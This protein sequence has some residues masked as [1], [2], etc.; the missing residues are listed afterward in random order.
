MVGFFLCAL[1]G[2]GA[3]LVLKP[4]LPRPVRRRLTII[5]VL[6]L[7]AAGILTWVIVRRYGPE[8]DIGQL[9]QDAT[10]GLVTAATVVALVIWG[11]NRTVRDGLGMLLIALIAVQTAISVSYFWPTGP[12]DAF[13]PDNPTI[14]AAREASNHDRVLPLGA[15][16]ARPDAPTVFEP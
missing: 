13:Y 9:W 6:G 12:R 7:A 8:T 14:T 4:R 1:A 2:V 15:F 3:N 16:P 10:L 11:R 5:G